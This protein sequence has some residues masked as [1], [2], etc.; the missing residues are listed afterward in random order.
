MKQRKHSKETISIIGFL[1]IAAI[2]GALIVRQRYFSQ[3]PEQTPSPETPQENP[4]DTTGEPENVQ[5]SEANENEIEITEPLIILTTPRNTA[6]NVDHTTKEIL[7]QQIPLFT[8][9]ILNDA[10]PKKIATFEGAIVH[11]D[12]DAHHIIRIDTA[13]DLQPN[14]HAYFTIEGNAFESPLYPTEGNL[15]SFFASKDGSATASTTASPLSDGTITIRTST[16]NE[17]HE[18]S[19]EDLPPSSSPWNSMA[20]LGLTS[21]GTT[22]LV[23]AEYKRN[24]VLKANGFFAYDTRKYSFEKI[25]TQER[26]NE[27]DELTTFVKTNDAN[28]TV[29]FEKTTSDGRS[30]VSYN[31]NTREETL[32]MAKDDTEGMRIEHPDHISPTNSHILLFDEREDRYILY[33]TIAQTTTPWAENR[34]PIGWLSE[35]MILAREGD[36]SFVVDLDGNDIVQRE[37][38]DDLQTILDIIHPKSAQR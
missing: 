17:P 23:L 9:N 18:L 3:P 6:E 22:L 36:S 13:N 16:S 29:I 26:I 1:I 8:W 21:D 4:R 32:L 28:D 15:V 11:M 14:G 30:F 31:A 25:S 35:K 10:A 37:S 7:T 19:I 34:Q 20:P 12:V 27:D 38:Q 24:N 2:A 5:S 33:D